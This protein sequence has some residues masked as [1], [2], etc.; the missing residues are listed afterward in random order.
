MWKK[1]IFFIF[2]FQNAVF[3]DNR[4]MCDMTR[5]ARYLPMG[6]LVGTHMFRR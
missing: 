2:L 5:S 6:G 3:N 1:L 4:I